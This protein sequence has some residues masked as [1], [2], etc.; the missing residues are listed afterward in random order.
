M[1]LA[2]HQEVV[3]AVRRPLEQVEA[4]EALVVM[5]AVQP[6]AIMRLQAV[7]A[8]AVMVEAALRQPEGTEVL[9]P[10]VA[11]VVLRFSTEVAE[12]VDRSKRLVLVPMVEAMGQPEG[13]VQRVPRIAEVVAEALDGVSSREAREALVL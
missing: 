3:P 4:P 9:V 13:T 8:M 10:Q 6:Q 7:E 5:E 1:V 11:S 2:E 12:V